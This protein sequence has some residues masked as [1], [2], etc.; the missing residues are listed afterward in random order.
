VIVGFIALE[1]VNHLVQNQ[2][3]LL[4]WDY[5]KGLRKTS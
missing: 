2:K 3:H 4:V 1:F 5:L